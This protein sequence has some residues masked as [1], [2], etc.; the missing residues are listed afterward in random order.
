VPSRA[1]YSISLN[2]F[3]VALILKAD[4]FVNP[5]S[6]TTRPWLSHIERWHDGSQ[7]AA[8]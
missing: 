8:E 1:T 4:A 3:Y 2:L 6:T 5:N 7:I